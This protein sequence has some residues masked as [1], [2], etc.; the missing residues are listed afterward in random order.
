MELWFGYW[1]NIQ[2]SP[3]MS[4]A[5]KRAPPTSVLS[6]LSWRFSLASHR[7]ADRR[8]LEK[9]LDGHKVSTS[10]TIRVR[11]NRLK[12]QQHHERSLTGPLGGPACLRGLTCFH[13]PLVGCAS[14]G[15]GHIGLLS[16]PE[17]DASNSSCELESVSHRNIGRRE[18]LAA[19][20]G[21]AS[22]LPRH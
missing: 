14:A 9:L 4:P 2:T 3:T 7:R 22:Q 12:L 5:A 18:H 11:I 16:L 17:G 10:E 1:R 21:R 19:K 20:I 13:G 15:A 8:T 6:T